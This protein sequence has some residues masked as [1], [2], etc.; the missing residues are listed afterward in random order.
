MTSFQ[1]A[2]PHFHSPLLPHDVIVSYSSPLAISDA[3]IVLNC[4]LHFS[5]LAAALT[6]K[7]FIFMLTKLHSTSFFFFSFLYILTSVIMVYTAPLLSHRCSIAE[8]VLIIISFFPFLVT[9]FCLMS[10]FWLILHV[11]NL[12]WTILSGAVFDK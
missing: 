7:I 8:S 4:V 3:D 5:F 6:F 12:V 1:L 11:T 9:I 2:A 10:P